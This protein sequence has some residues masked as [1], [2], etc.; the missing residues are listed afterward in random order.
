M[1]I[2][3]LHKTA[4]LI[5]ALSPHGDLVCRRVDLKNDGLALLTQRRKNALPVVLVPQL[6]QDAE[7]LHIEEVRCFPIQHQPDKRF[8]IVG[9]CSPR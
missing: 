9:Q 8:P 5:E 7:M 1:Q 3:I 6:R 4:A 2:G